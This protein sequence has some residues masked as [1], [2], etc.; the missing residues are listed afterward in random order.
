MKGN[1]FVIITKV[2]K[3]ALK[4]YNFFFILGLILLFTSISFSEELPRPTYDNSLIFAMTYG[5]NSSASEI[6]IIKNQFGNGI[7]A[8]LYFT[9]F[10][11]IEMDWSTLPENADAGIQS[12]KNQV[13]GLIAKAKEY[14]VGLHIIINYG[15]SR[16]VNTYK[17]AK[18]EDIRNGQWY[19]DNN[20]AAADQ[21]SGVMNDK[22]FGT[23]SR[24]ARKLREFHEAKIEAMFDFLKQKQDDNPDLTMV[25]SGPGE[26]ELNFWRIIH[27]QS[28]Q[29]YFCDYSPFAVLEFRDWIRHAGMY[30]TG[31]KYAG[32]GYGN[33]G[34]RYQGTN[35]LQNFNSD[36]GTNFSN[37][38][39]KY[40]NW[41]LQDSF[42]ENAVPFVNYSFNGQ[43]PVTGPYYIGGGFDPPR[44]M[45]QKGEDGFWDLWHS[46]R[47][48]LVAH[49]VKDMASI[50][51]NSEFPKKQYY[52]HQIPADHLFG[53]QPNDPDHPFLNPRYYSSA[54]PMWTADAFSDIGMAIT[55]YDLKINADLFFRTSRY[56]DQNI[57]NMSSNWAALEYNPEVHPEAGIPMSSVQDIY[58]RIIRLYE[59]D[60]HM[61]SFFYWQG[62]AEWQY[63]DTNRGLAAVQFFNAIKDC[64]RQA[65]GVEFTP[66]VVNGFSG[67]FNGV[68]GK[69]DLDW[70]DKIWSDLNHK[71]SH[72]DDFKEFVIFRGYSPDFAGNPSSEIG[73]VADI[74][75]SDAGFDMGRIVYYKIAAVNSNGY[76]G[77][78]VSSGPVNPSAIPIGIL[79]VSRASFIFAANPEEDVTSSQQFM[80]LNEGTADMTWTAVKDASWLECSPV[81]GTNSQVVSIIVNPSGLSQGIYDGSIIVSSANALNSPKIVNVT[82]KVLTSSQTQPPIGYWDTPVDGAT[83]LRG[84]IPVTGWAL[85]D[86]EV[87][88]VEIWRRA[89]PLRQ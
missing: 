88:R 16:N 24:Y 22:V 89:E 58:E 44:V 20:L 31:S 3:M 75:Y 72:W 87:D 5:L 32:E 14:E 30:A 4:K 26:V 62:S 13:E 70:S 35:G 79:N 57:K 50:A 74:S 8:P 48:L 21:L 73:R 54:S 7:Y 76:V 10:V 36:F 52:T 84:Q 37:W 81:F 17:E 63:K 40:Y 68:S 80:V 64:A 12:F 53:T 51:R 45:K 1:S 60:A 43:M 39:L 59:N 47:E 71:W 11:M 33:G 18:E 85:D 9:H 29:D 86:I 83:Q 27:S 23:F 55:L 42:E 56:A 66:P 78:V 25:V 77:D 65:L 2:R 15:L 34:A 67:I 28:L 61:I 46:F 38:A 49:Y 41:S 82:L 19:N 69:I 6:N